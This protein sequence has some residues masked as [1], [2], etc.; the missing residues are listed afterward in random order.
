MSNGIPDNTMKGLF[1]RPWVVAVAIFLVILN[2]AQPDWFD[3]V[4]AWLDQIF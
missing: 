2:A 3:H 1:R 4:T